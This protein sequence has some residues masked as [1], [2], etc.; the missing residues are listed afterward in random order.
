LADDINSLNT[1]IIS[2]LSLAYEF[3]TVAE[4]KA[5]ATAFPVGKVI[6]LLDRKASF[7]VISGTGTGNDEDIISSTEVTQ[8]ITISVGLVIDLK[9][10]GVTDGDNITSV[11][12][13]AATKYQI[14]IILS[15]DVLCDEITGMD[16]LDL[17]LQGATI[18]G[19]GGDNL[20]K[21]IKRFFMSGKGEIGT[22]TPYAA[23]VYKVE[24]GSILDD[25]IVIGEILIDCG[26]TTITG[27]WCDPGVAATV[28]PNVKIT[29]IEITGFTRSGIELAMDAAL[30][31][32]S[33]YVSRVKSHSG[34][35]RCIQFGN[36][37]NSCWNV[38]VEDCPRIGDI[39]SGGSAEAKGVL[40]Y[41]ENVLV[42]NNTVERI[43]NSGVSGA[44]GIYVK[45]SFC[46]ITNNK[47]LNAGSSSDG[48]IT[49][50]GAEYFEGELIPQGEWSVITGNKVR[51]TDITYDSKGIG[52]FDSNVL[53]HHNILI[54]QRPTRSTL[55][56][57]MA[58]SV[59]GSNAV[60]NVI[61]DNNESIGWK[62]FSGDFSESFKGRQRFVDNIKIRNNTAINLVGDNAAMFRADA[63]LETRPLTYDS[64]AK[65]ITIVGTTGQNA[66]FGLMVYPIGSSIIVSGTST[67]DGTYTVTALSRYVMTVAEALNTI[68]EDSNITRSE[69]HNLE[70]KG[71]TF[72]GCT[73]AI[74]NFAGKVRNML[75][76]GNTYIDMTN[77]Y[78]L[79]QA[80][81]IGELTIGSN[82]TYQNVTTVQFGIPVADTTKRGV[83]I[84][85][86]TGT[87]I[88]LES[89]N[90][91][92][93]IVYT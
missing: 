91:S 27:F 6:N 11:L 39:V 79:D 49:I 10:W 80:N 14:P 52:I 40:I 12:T 19:T 34:A 26:T 22:T 78:R 30:T 65:T 54:D 37:D 66:Q 81:G 48:C 93:D 83:N 68:T 50:K 74:R 32:A 25:L 71:N 33:F 75:L 67:N 77:A 21:N 44:E 88:T 15:N 56:Y 64:G 51:M 9:K 63:E 35:G 36:N 82:E 89:Y 47:M 23:Y 31:D 28:A 62:T 13:N 70:I 4:Y 85:A 17:R 3:A 55:T 86:D 57:S 20:F 90:K 72:Q 29:D 92:H 18:N 5:F 43:K 61:V 42:D 60:S 53:C 8:S 46:S 1:S 84:T 2:D 41:G 58:V 45:A 24:T 16:Y 69:I 76:D 7:T 73:T 59:G 87:V 38:T